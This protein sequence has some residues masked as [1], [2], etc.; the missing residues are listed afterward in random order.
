M[1][2][3]KTITKGEIHE[4][5][6]INEFIFIGIPTPDALVDLPRQA[7][8]EEEWRQMHQ[9]DAICQFLITKHNI[10]RIWRRGRLFCMTVRNFLTEFFDKDYPPFD[11]FIALTR[12]L[13][14]NPEALFWILKFKWRSE[15]RKQY[16]GKLPDIHRVDEENSAL[17]EFIEKGEIRKRS[18]EDKKTFKKLATPEYYKFF[19]G[20]LKVDHFRDPRKDR[21]KPRVLKEKKKKEKKVEDVEFEEIQLLEKEFKV[22]R[23]KGPYQKHNTSKVRTISAKGEILKL[24]WVFDNGERIECKRIPKEGEA[25]RPGY[26]GVPPHKGINKWVEMVFKG[27]D[28]V[29]ETRVLKEGQIF[30]L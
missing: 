3:K 22:I 7:D 4:D 24:E 6:H 19:L 20:F 13:N 16:I 11:I 26:T 25:V 8:E 21:R 14:I 18:V 28:G 17:W 10:D 15:I 29:V 12:N 27:I 30:K 5:E 2:L 23:H 9:L 1:F